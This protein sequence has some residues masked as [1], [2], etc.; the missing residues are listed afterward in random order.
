[1]GT[2]VRRVGTEASSN[3]RTADFGSAYEG[4]NPSASISTS[5]KPANLRAELRPHRRPASLLLVALG[6][7]R[8]RLQDAVRGALREVLALEAVVGPALERPQYAFNEAR[9]QYHASAIL[10]RLSA[11]RPSGAPAPVLGLADVDLFVPDA[12]YVLGEADRGAGVAL[13]STA[14]LFTRDLG[15]LVH[16]ASVEAVHEAGHLLG[17]GHC[18]DRRCAMYLSRDTSEVDRKGPGLCLACR[19]ALGLG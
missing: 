4:S 15:V 2:P 1:V 11:L 13:V 9:G 17:L 12:D 6:A 8:A 16:R 7:A 5:G 10:R 19:A 3:G 18:L 14:R